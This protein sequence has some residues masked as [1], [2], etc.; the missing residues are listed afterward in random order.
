MDAWRR[1]RRCVSAGPLLT[2]AHHIHSHC[3][4]FEVRM[5]CSVSW[6]VFEC[7][8]MNLVKI[9]YVGVKE[10]EAEGQRAIIVSR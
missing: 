6:Q 5:C 7:N 10:E 2:N 1:L 4:K 8:K 9:V 3:S